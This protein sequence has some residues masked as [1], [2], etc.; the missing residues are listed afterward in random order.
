MRLVLVALAVIGCGCNDSRPS[1][2]SPDANEGGCV[3]D[4]IEDCGRSG[5]LCE[6]HACVDPWRYG[7]PQWSRC[8]NASRATPETLA[9]KAA[10]YDV[11]L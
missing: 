3:A 8:D 6:N 1:D 11:R 5:Q 4:E 9:Q 10:A 2:A 7:S